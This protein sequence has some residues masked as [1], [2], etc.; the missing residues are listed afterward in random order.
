MLGPLA[1]MSNTSTRPDHVPVEP[2]PHRWLPYPPESPATILSTPVI[3]ET[4]VT[5][6]PLTVPPVLPLHQL[7][8]F[9][10]TLPL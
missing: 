4:L 2:V 5:N 9:Y 7:P 1:G 6:P 8:L 3:P 10:P